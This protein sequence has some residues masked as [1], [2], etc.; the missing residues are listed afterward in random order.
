MNRFVKSVSVEVE[1]PDGS[2]TLVIRE[3]LGA[4]RSVY[5]AGSLPW[6][7]AQV[8]LEELG[9]ADAHL[10]AASGGDAPISSRPTRSRPEA[11][12]PSSRRAFR[13][14][15]AAPR[16]RAHSG[17][18]AMALLLDELT[19]AV[20]RTGRLQPTST[21][22][23]L[24][25]R[26][27]LA[28]AE[29]LQLARVLARLED[30]LAPGGTALHAALALAALSEMAERIRGLS[31]AT[32]DELT[33]PA[34]VRPFEPCELLELGRRRERGAVRAETRILVDLASGEL[35]C[36][37]SGRGG[38]SPSRGPVG[39]HLCVTLGRRIPAAGY[40]RIHIQHYEYDPA[41]SIDQLEHVCHLASSGLPA[42]SSGGL[43]LVA[44]PHPVFVQVRSLEGG[45]PR[46]VCLGGTAVRLD[47]GS[48]AGV[49][50]ALFEQT[51]AGV[52]VDALAGTLE[53][54]HR[55]GSDSGLV[56][57]PWSIIVADAAGRRLMPL[58][59]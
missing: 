15:D 17:S 32:H 19:H 1:H 38:P 41:P 39:R 31:D 21:V 7:V 48:C 24:L 3:P 45:C 11:S 4:R 26:A 59:Y 54:S 50:Q 9:L 25:E 20:V 56:L 37:S 16:P 13:I 27:W 33:G 55:P 42:L 57:V 28:A 30:S 5:V 6:H 43:E 40:S 36:E 58:S 18:E 35:L 49:V 14:E 12:R 2:G 22:D 10:L 29:N 53:L 52:R 46:V 47:D 51:R 34:L 8:V 23:E 44:S